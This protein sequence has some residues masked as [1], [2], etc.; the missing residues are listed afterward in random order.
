MVGSSRNSSFRPVNQRRRQIT[1][2]PL[3]QRDCRTGVRAGRRCPSPG[4]PCAGLL[5]IRPFQVIQIAQQIEAVLHRQIPPELRA[6]A[7]HHADIPRVGDSLFPRHAAQT[8]HLSRCRRQ[9]AG[10]ALDGGGFYLRRSARCTPTNSPGCTPK[11]T[12]PSASTLDFSRGE[13]RCFPPFAHNKAHAELSTEMISSILYPFRPR[14]RPTVGN[15][16]SSHAEGATKRPGGSA[17]P[18]SFDV[19]AYYM[20]LF[21]FKFLLHF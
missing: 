13:N 7:E 12:P 1:A 19:R 15:A 11:D 16:P 8:A 18:P 4:E 2:H 20:S 14:I 21:S 9:N 17:R 5:V 10:Q 3:P 6:L